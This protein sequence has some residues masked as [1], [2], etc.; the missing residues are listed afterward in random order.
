LY[1]WNV[2]RK[3]MATGSPAI[4]HAVGGA[5]GSSFS[6]WLLYPLE[7]ARIE[8]QMQQ[9]SSSSSPEQQTR[10]RNGDHDPRIS[11]AADGDTDDG[12]VEVIFESAEEESWQDAMTEA[13]GAVPG[14]IQTS[15]SMD[16]DP[17]VVVAACP[18]HRR[19]QDDD[20]DGG[21]GTIVSCIRRL[22]KKHVLYIGVSTIALTTG[23]SNFIFFYLNEVI[24]QFL[25]PP[26]RSGRVGPMSPGRL[27]LAS[28]LAG[29]C[30][31][32][33]TN[34]LWVANMNLLS[35]QGHHHNSNEASTASSSSSGAAL[36][37]LYTELRR[38]VKE[39]GWTHLWAG[40]GAS[41]LLVTNPI[42]QFFVYE[43]LKSRLWLAPVITNHNNVRAFVNG[44]LAKLVATVVTYPLQLSQT[45]LRSSSGDDTTYQST[46][47]CLVTL[48]R[49]HGY[50]A[51]FRG[52]KAKLLQTVL[53]AA[54]TFLTYEQIV[55]ALTAMVGRVQDN[56]RAERRM[57]KWS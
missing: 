17:H 11:N 39:K 14:D 38:I 36:G 45:I 41:L 29:V 35:S 31:V 8:L 16:M 13:S 54:F 53:T 49:Q 5:L 19:F 30:N 55:V 4:V 20:D 18:G 6:I 46:W 42:L 57:A 52:L 33:I 25:A 2:I 27:L 28:F 7:R 37:R 48:Y 44:A 21:A 23:I 47:D 40:T 15:T 50:R 32:C 24:K 10:T 12:E 56:K 1:T 22:R 43:E 34:P 51:L 26:D 9:R 3:G